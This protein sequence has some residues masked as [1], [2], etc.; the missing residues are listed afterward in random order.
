MV[1][2]RTM[3]EPS[4]RIPLIV[5]Y[6]PVFKQPRVL[7]QMVLTVDIAPTILDLCGQPPLPKIHG[8]SFKNIARTGQGEWRSAFYYSYDYEKQF[9]Y[10]PNVRGIRTAD[11][12]YIHY[13]PGDGGPERHLAELYHLAVDPE[14][15]HNLIADPSQASRLRQLKKQLE[16]LMQR[17]GALP[18]KMPLDE[19]VK[20]ELPDPNIR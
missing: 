7:K 10:T 2:K 1:D 20:A 13:P 19:G 8:R 12:K 16:H 11:W 4:I 9:P 18:D 17:T 15:R 6:P 14:E 3:H 5:R